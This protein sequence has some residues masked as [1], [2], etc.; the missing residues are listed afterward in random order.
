MLVFGFH[1]LLLSIVCKSDIM[2]YSGK[3]GIKINSIFVSSTFISHDLPKVQNYVVLDCW[4]GKTKRTFFYPFQPL[5]LPS[6]EHLQNINQ[7]FLFDFFVS[8]HSAREAGQE[9]V[10]SQGTKGRTRL[11]K[12]RKTLAVAESAWIPQSTVQKMTSVLVHSLREDF[13]SLF[14]RREP[15]KLPAL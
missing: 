8:L 2:A 11:N 1:L 12:K 5:A 14:Q 10:T 13:I 7:F 3:H 9:R 15:G 4:K 6:Q